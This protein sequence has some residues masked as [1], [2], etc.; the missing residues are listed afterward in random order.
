M[1]RD[2]LPGP[3]PS[4][5]G[6]VPPRGGV[7]RLG[8]ACPASGGVSRLGGA[9][10][11][12]AAANGAALPPGITLGAAGSSPRRRVL[13]RME[14]PFCRAA[15]LPGGLC[16][17]E[18][19]FAPLPP[20]PQFPEPFR[21][22]KAGPCPD[23]GF[24]G[25]AAAA[26]GFFYPPPGD[27]DAF[28]GSFAPALD[29]LNQPGPPNVAL[30]EPPPGGPAP[31]G[32]FAGVP[33]QAEAAAAA[34]GSPERAAAE[35]RR[36]RN[37]LAASRCRRRKLERLQRLEQRVRGLRAQNAAL[38][39]AAAGLRAHV[40]RLRGSVREH[41]GSGCPLPHSGAALGL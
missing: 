9:C 26:A 6:R 24:F 7:S 1:P 17:P 34:P 8:G 32:P 5:G 40:R 16:R 35:R 22:L 15:P 39:A 14:P 12:G 41:A 29:E 19:D 25:G 2:S 3:A 11:S 20:A 33:A 21:G 23:G 13:P 27:R 36:L 10:P 38:A 31:G 37:R 18:P 4:S 30:P 28:G